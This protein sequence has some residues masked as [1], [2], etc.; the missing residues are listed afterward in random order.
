MS[1]NVV[2]D[3]GAGG[4]MVTVTTYHNNGL[5]HRIKRWWKRLSGHE[6][7]LGSAKERDME[8]RSGA[9]GTFSMSNNEEGGGTLTWKV[10][11]GE[12]HIQ[13]KWQRVLEHDIHRLRKAV[14]V[15]E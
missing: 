3:R 14:T 1:S 13:K 6:K 10:L 15:D 4:G 2:H 9:E 5:W 11:N 12:E 8:S 7:P